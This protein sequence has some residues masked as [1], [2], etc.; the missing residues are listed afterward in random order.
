MKHLLL[1]FLFFSLNVYG[2]EFENISCFSTEAKGGGSPNIFRS[3][4]IGKVINI[5]ASEIE[6]HK[7]WS[8]N[9]D[10]TEFIVVKKDFIK[11]S[12]S[13]EIYR[14]INGEFHVTFKNNNGENVFRRIVPKL[15]PEKG[16]M[17]QVNINGSRLTFTNINNL[18]CQK[19]LF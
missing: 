14:I 13:D 3:I 1:L 16:Y 17:E 18:E 11:G 15:L 2:Y 9:S 8:Q 19:E 12:T 10:S 5:P 6:K 7:E 4:H